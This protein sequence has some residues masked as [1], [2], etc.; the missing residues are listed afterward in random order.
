MASECS[1]PI[2]TQGSDSVSTQL[3]RE[4]TVELGLSAAQVRA[5]VNA[6]Q[7][8]SLCS[9]RCAHLELVIAG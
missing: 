2:V 4:L 8:M 7:L 5:I 9:L 6:A 1:S 3:T